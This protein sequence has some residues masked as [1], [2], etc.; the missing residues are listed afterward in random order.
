MSEEDKA[1]GLWR[2]LLEWIGDYPWQES[3]YDL[4]STCFFC[5]EDYPEHKSNCVYLAAKKLIE[6]NE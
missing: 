4:D 3:N 6:G 2:R 1:L 5:G